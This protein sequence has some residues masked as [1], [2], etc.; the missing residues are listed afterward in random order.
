MNNR[1]FKTSVLALGLAAFSMQ[2]LA[3][4]CRTVH[5]SPGTVINVNSAMYLGTRIQFPADLVSNPASPNRELWTSDGAATTLLV[6]PNSKEAEGRATILRAFT[7]DGHVY[8]IKAN[9]VSSERND[10]CVIVNHDGQFFTAGSKQAL[11]ANAQQ[12]GQASAASNMQLMEMRRE[13]LEQGQQARDSEKKAVMEALSRYRYHIYTRYEWD[14]GK[15]FAASNLISDVY[16]DG[17]WTYIRLNT[18]NRGL[19]S[20]ESEI[21]EKNAIVPVKYNDRYGM[22][23][24]N[25]IYPRFTLRVDDARIGIERA[26]AQTQGD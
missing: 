22:Y 24:I 1:I 19:L 2:A 10:T 9:R 13:M 6:K 7:T 12:L 21:G 14:Q 3:E 15:G 5:W 16:D 8:D 25:G 20:V 23:Q 17:R 26:D 11:R 18:P 4:S